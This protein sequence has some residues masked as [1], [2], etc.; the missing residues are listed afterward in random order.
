[1]LLIKQIPPE[2][3][4]MIPNTHAKTSRKS[5]AGIRITLLC[6]ETRMNQNQIGPN[7]GRFGVIEQPEEN[8]SLKMVSYSGFPT[9][10][11]QGLEQVIQTFWASTTLATEWRTVYRRTKGRGGCS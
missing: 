8:S 5:A 4:S 7:Q 6:E 2:L 10:P 1:M 11:L 9:K 3:Q